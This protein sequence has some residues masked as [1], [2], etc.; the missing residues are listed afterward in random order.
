[1][2]D[3]G[4]AITF[5]R[6]IV[7]YLSWNLSN[8]Q[9]L[10]SDDADVNLPINV[11]DRTFTPSANRT[12]LPVT[13]PTIYCTVLYQNTL[14]LTSQR[15]YQRVLSSSPPSLQ[16]IAE[17]DAE[18]VAWLGHLPDWMT[19]AS[20]T[21]D[22][23]QW[24]QFSVHKLFWRYCNLRI[25]LHRRAFL[26]RALTGKPLVA[27]SD[28]GLVGSDPDSSSALSCLR[29]SMDTIDA[30]RDF[31]QVE[32]PSRL[33]TWYGLHFLFHASFVP[34]IALKMDVASSARLLWSNSVYQARDVLQILA[35]HEVLAEKFLKLLSLVDDFPT[36]SLSS[37]L[38]NGDMA[39]EAGTEK[40][41]AGLTGGNAAW[42]E[43][44]GEEPSN[45]AQTL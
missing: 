38:L 40:L 29:A 10:P 19:I 18:L 21:P 17:M 8:P 16:E 6:P 5:G 43:I 1:M 41:W 45:L 22:Q 23:P 25:I 32:P 15:I 9:L 35:P 11:H 26:E 27:N 44:F 2:F 24:L 34:L 4:A 20:I 37:T 3:A 12:P 39:T 14:H 31:F 33:Q 28:L 13:Q 7:G 36:G 30:V 42:S